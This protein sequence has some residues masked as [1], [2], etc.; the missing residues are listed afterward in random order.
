MAAVLRTTSV[1]D[2]IK[3]VANLGRDR[4]RQPARNQFVFFKLTMTISFFNGWCESKPAATA[5]V[6]TRFLQR[7]LEPGPRPFTGRGLKKSKTVCNPGSSAISSEK[8]RSKTIFRQRMNY[9]VM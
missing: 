8:Q 1:S 7:T 5:E 9:A 2:A 6:S 3:R 4:E